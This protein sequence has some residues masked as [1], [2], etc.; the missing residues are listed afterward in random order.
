MRR[1]VKNMRDLTDVVRRLEEIPE[2]GWL[3]EYKVYQPPRTKCQN[4]KVHAMFS[5]LADFT[6]DKD[7]K[8]FI[9]ELNFWP[10]EI[11]TQFGVQVER[12]MSESKLTRE[13]ESD[14]IEHLYMLGAEL[15]GF[16]WSDR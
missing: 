7:I 2:Q 8:A 6:G 9:K 1:V 4:R 10:T 15:P 3:V 14:V 11:A 5:D 13:Q 12:P 16:E